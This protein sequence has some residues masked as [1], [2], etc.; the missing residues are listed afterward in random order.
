MEKVTISK[1]LLHALLIHVYA[2]GFG[3]GL[4]R[5]QV[6]D[7]STEAEIFDRLED[8]FPDERIEELFPGEFDFQND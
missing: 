1:E 6:T 5:E 7:E 2:E 4:T 8:E 3:E